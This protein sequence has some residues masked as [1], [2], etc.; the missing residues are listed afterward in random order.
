MSEEIR[1]IPG[2]EGYGIT[3]DARVFDMTT[4]EPTQ[5]PEHIAAGGYRAVSVRVEGYTYLRSRYVHRLLVAA[6]GEPAPSPAHNLYFVDQ[7]H[8]NVT[9]GNLKWLTIGDI[10]KLDPDPDRRRGEQNANAKLNADA[11]EQIWSMLASG[12]G[13]RRIA[14]AF[15][16]HISTIYM[17]RHKRAWRHVTAKLEA[18]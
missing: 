1:P 13:A 5:L 12:Y 4:P 6:W 17:I 15:G 10:R 9:L 8:N 14:H 16:V 11:V 3:V 7:D 18:A 2:F